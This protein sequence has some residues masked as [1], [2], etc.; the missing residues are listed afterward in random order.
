M[1]GFGLW[2]VWDPAKYSAKWC[3]HV[4]ARVPGNRTDLLIDQQSYYRFVVGCFYQL[5]YSQPGNGK[6]LGLDRLRPKPR[7]L[8]CRLCDHG[9]G[10]RCGGNE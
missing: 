10:D 4:H 6:L 2:L 5:R 1:S 3:V 8:Q 7:S 9:I